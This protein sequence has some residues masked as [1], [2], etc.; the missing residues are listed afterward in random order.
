MAHTSP[1]RFGIAGLDHWY[2]AFPFA[3]A[4]AASANATLVAVADPDIERAR[5]L[6]QRAGVERVTADP[7]ELAEDAGIDVIA[8]FIS[9]DRNPELCVAAARAGKHI[10]SVKPMA[11]ALGEATEILTAVRQAGIVFLPAESRNRLSEQS[12]LLKQWVAE[13][14]LGRILTASYSLWAPLPRKWP[15]DSDPGWFA[16]P[17]RSPGG[18]WIDHSIYQIDLLRWLLG[19]EVAQISGRM[20]NLRYPD[21]PVEDYGVAVATFGTGAVATIED[22]WHAA[23]GAFR[24]HMS[25]A[26]TEGA[27]ATD[28]LTGRLSVAGGF[29]PFEGWVHTAPRPA[30]TDAVDHLVALVRGE[31]EPVATVED[32]W[33]NLAA[34]LAGYEAARSGTPVTPDA[35]PAG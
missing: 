2:S 25:L 34:C 27:L 9:V 11:R 8:S 31:R 14:R 33:R 19:D 22:T 29:P 4:L 6:A 16:D 5:T 17:A 30:N 24:M 21:L 10:L 7:Q 3:D 12:A 1:V 23:P 26:G 35:L 28:S 20:A 32:A 15:G 18:G 13:G